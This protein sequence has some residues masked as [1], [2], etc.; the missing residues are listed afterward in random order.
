LLIIGPPKPKRPHHATKTVHRCQR[1]L[2]YQNKCD[3]V[4]REPPRLETAF[5]AWY[6]TSPNCATEDGNLHNWKRYECDCRCDGKYLPLLPPSNAPG[7]GVSTSVGLCFLFLDTGECILSQVPTA[8][9]DVDLTADFGFPNIR[10]NN[11]QTCC[12]WS[13]RGATWI[14]HGSNHRLLCLIQTSRPK[15][16]NCLGLLRRICLVH[17]S[18]RLLGNTFEMKLA[19]NTS[20]KFYSYVELP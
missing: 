20:I 18:F 13:N 2:C 14:Q 6:G 5:N 10:Q 16:R 9:D 15:S 17:R 19:W 11:P 4:S 1:R 3:A 7:R 8:F 12:L